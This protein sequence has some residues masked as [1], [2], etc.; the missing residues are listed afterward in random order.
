MLADFNAGVF[1]LQPVLTTTVY[2]ARDAVG[3]LMSFKGVDE[4][5]GTA[6]LLSL[7][8]IDIK[9]KAPGIDVIFYSQT[10]G[11][12]ITDNAALSITAADH[13]LYYLGRISF[14][15]SDWVSSSTQ[16]VAS[17]VVDAT[18][19]AASCGIKLKST[20]ADGLIYVVFMCVT[21]PSAAYAAGAGDLTFKFGIDQ[22]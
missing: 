18:K 1:T 17:N 19:A 10:P 16:N 5:K 13:A 8:A 4:N 7:T 15:A 12:T 3:S 9:A 21:V 14:G 11:G 2:A 20:G 22:D 6:T